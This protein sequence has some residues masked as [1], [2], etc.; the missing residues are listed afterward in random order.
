MRLEGERIYLD[1]L[2]RADCRA[3]F[4]QTEFDPDALVEPP[5]IGF[6]PER[7]DE[8]YDDIQRRQ[9]DTH[10]RLGIFVRAQD[11]GRGELVG[12][13]ALQDINWRDRS[14]SVGM[15][16]ARLSDRGQGYGAEALRLMLGYGFDALGLERIEARTLDVNAR[17]RRLLERTGF[18][19]EGRERAAVYLGG[20]RR[21]RLLYGMLR[22]EWAQV[23]LERAGGR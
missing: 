20:A 2:T 8:W 14:C 1:M 13:V 10:V 17:A 6:G 19:C 18:V 11:G 12:D 23:K 21:D 9:C 5:C 16:M 3:L 7:A 4:E 22:A 15:G